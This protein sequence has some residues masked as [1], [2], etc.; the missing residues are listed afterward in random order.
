MIPTPST[1]DTGR[2]R[3]VHALMLVVPAVA[4]LFVAVPL[5]APN[6]APLGVLL[7]GAELGGVNGL[8]ALG[9]ILTYRA[10]RVINFSYGAMGALAGT[11]GVML[12]LGAGLNWFASLC[13]GLVAGA[14]LGA[15]VD[16]LFR[17]RFSRT[18][19]LLV[20]VA[21]IGL[22][23]VFGGI[24]ALV[25]G[26]L[27]GP[28]LL[29]AFSTPLS[30]FSFTIR[31]VLFDGNDLVALG[32]LLSVPAALGWFLLRTR[33][34]VAIR[35]LAEN[36]ERA[37]LLGIPARRL[38]MVV[39]T[40]AGTLAALTV[41][42]NGPSLG[43]TSSVLAGP[44]LILPALAAA[45]IARMERLTVAFGSAVLIG[46]LNAVVGFNVS[47]Q[48]ITDVVLLAV[49]LVALLFQHRQRAAKGGGDDVW[50]GSG[51]V[52]PIPAALRRLPEVVGARVLVA[53]AVGAVLVAVPF[54][55][56]PG[57]TS[58]YTAAECF[59][60]G[61][62][63]LVVLSGWSGVVSLGQFAFAGVG[64]VI[65]GDLVEKA[66]VDFF[67]CLAAA[68]VGGALLAVVIGLPALRV[69]GEYLA[70]TTL[71]L[72]VA[73]NSFF[74]NPTNFA[75]IIPADFLRPLV[76]NRFDLSDDRTYYY[77]CLVL[78]VLGALFVSGLR[79]TRSGRVLLAAR[80][81]L[82]A[83]EAMAVPTV[84]VRLGAFSLAG[85][86]AGLA[87]ALYATELGSVGL[88]TFD[89]SVS[90]LIFSMA[91]IGGLGS[92]WGA[93][94]GVA[95]VEAAT[96]SFPSYQQIIAGAGLLVVLVVLPGGI[97]EGI[98]FVR[99]LLLRTVARRHHLPVPTMIGQRVATD[100]SV[101]RAVPAAR[102]GG[103]EA[104]LACE[105]VMASY[106][107][108]RTLF[109]VDLTVEDNEVV[110][111]LGTNGAGKSTLLRSICGL[112]D[113]DEGQVRLRGERIDGAGPEGVARR[114]VALMPGGRG[115]FGGLS[116]EDN[117]TLAAWMLRKE[118]VR[119]RAGRDEVLELFPVLGDRLAVRAGSL[120]GGE[121]Q[122]LSLA[123][124]LVVTP[125][126]LLIDELSL[127]LA[128]TVVG[129]LLGVVDRLHA[130]GMTIVIVEQSVNVALGMAQR[131]VFMEKG[132]VRFDGP[133]R[134]LLAR[135][136]LLRSVF[137][138]GAAKAFGS[139]HRPAAAARAPG[140]G[141]GERIGDEAV[142]ECRG[143]SKRFGGVHALSG[144]DL[145]VRQGEV[146]GLLGH[147]GAGK[148]T[149][150]DLISGFVAQDSGTIRLAGIDVSADAPHV[151]AGAGLGRSFQEARLYP[152]L[153]VRET[154]G[155]AFEQHV[156]SRSIAA[157]GFRLPAS[158]DSEHVTRRNVDA[159]VEL[160]G[161]GDFAEKLVAEL[162]TGTRRILE[163]ACVMAQAPRI[164]LLDEPSA[165]VAQRETEAMAPLLERVRHEIGCSMLVIEHDMPLLSSICDRL[166]A[167]ELGQV[168]A[169]GGPDEVL[170]HPRV[171]ASY[172][173]TDDSAIARSGS[174]TD[175]AGVT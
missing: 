148:T 83:A 100:G 66:N 22:G 1:L 123:M 155:V 88:N 93:M 142:L 152:S 104:V 78:L 72:A 140:P 101:P 121:Q 157:A 112:M 84:R 25:P 18:P 82:D 59:G 34:G 124:A 107:P 128:P 20:M 174:T 126:L 50:L 26:W 109:G 110:A 55:G 15:G 39:W 23:Q 62:L 133:S 129:D 13:I 85:A 163:L 51:V 6:T 94:L 57:T 12:Y 153:T 116:V 145:S 118:P 77:F 111:L 81:N 35:S 156:A 143:V 29:G 127:G 54:L 135:H 3:A 30:R 11:L 21:T 139:G 37:R 134:E 166:I 162:S 14:L 102:T 67:Q 46:I 71:A 38:S 76:W 146:V 44:T 138:E 161:L 47:Q 32:V 160:M 36:P 70:V 167:L 49:I 122:M 173:G 114:G 27:H 87:G 168:I 96:Y 151:R 113:L 33:S 75:R 103:E 56:G 158:L 42:V 31:P 98:T 73:M 170:A 97:S 159:L 169:E 19:R 45:V 147:N 64:G 154:L 120:S 91:V 99:D 130:S 5:L 137:L 65:A 132:E 150:M 165:G 141:P 16:L 52:R 60:L 68:A 115:I 131:A 53:L 117:L 80:D 17:W 74:L 79:R 41:M 172:L 149:L 92:I 7:N 61:A 90:L 69:R 9:L 2:A 89:P 4:V 108:V 119:A 10:N 175:F 144:V 40:V 125:Q 48:S 171:I 86:L 24:Q 63:S 58:E 105:G 43:V 164:V 8:L 106:G 136:D 95:L 28:E